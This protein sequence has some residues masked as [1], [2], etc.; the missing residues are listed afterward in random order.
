M[1]NGDLEQRRGCVVETAE[2]QSIGSN[3]P[4]LM[5]QVKKE[6]GEIAYE[7]IRKFHIHR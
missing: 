6:K 2:R 1:R 5:R 7:Q 3:L 4:I